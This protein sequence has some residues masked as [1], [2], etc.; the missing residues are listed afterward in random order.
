ML[1]PHRKEPSVSG[2]LTVAPP[3]TIQPKRCVGRARRRL[4]RVL[5]GLSFVLG[6]TISGAAFWLHRHV[7]VVAPNVPAVDPYTALF[8]LTPLTVTITA[9]TERLPWPTT[10]HDTGFRRSRLPSRH[11][12]RERQLWH[13]LPQHGASSTVEVHSQPRRA[14]GMG[15]MA[16]SADDR[17]R[18]MALDEEAPLVVGVRMRDHIASSFATA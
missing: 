2:A 12:G 7:D 4:Q 14:P 17:T 18:G 6:L 3:A 1:R 13:D 11:S 8:D 16:K 9:A 5:I 10:V 15:L